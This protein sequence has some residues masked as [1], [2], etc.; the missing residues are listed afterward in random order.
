MS[1]SDD[2]RKH[3]EKQL[4]MTIKIQETLEFSQHPDTGAANWA[5]M[6]LVSALAFSTL[7]DTPFSTRLEGN[8]LTALCFRNSPIENVHS[9]LTSLGDKEMKG[10]NVWSSRAL[11]G[12]LALKEI[13]FSLGQTVKNFGRL[14]LSRTTNITV[15]IG[16]PPTKFRLMKSNNAH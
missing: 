8:A 16:K 10:I 13:C 4:R 14:A 6:N 15:R 1:N 12:A 2:Q 3:A 9:G 11:T 5:M 7:T